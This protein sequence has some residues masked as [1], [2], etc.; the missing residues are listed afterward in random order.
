VQSCG[1]RGCVPEAPML[2]GDQ[3]TWG[4]GVVLVRAQRV[5]FSAPVLRVLAS[6]AGHWP[7]DVGTSPQYNHVVRR[8][9]G[10]HA[11]SG[12]SGTFCLAYFISIAEFSALPTF[13][14]ILSG[15]ALFVLSSA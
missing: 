14:A 1:K 7:G 6:H 2:C 15:K 8:R 13:F 4:E 3:P 9:T 10:R 11:L 12:S 5:R